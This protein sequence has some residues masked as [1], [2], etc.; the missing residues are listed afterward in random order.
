MVELEESE[1]S[2]MNMTIHAASQFFA[3]YSGMKG[4][5][6]NYIILLVLNYSKF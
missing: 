3:H 6:P 2:S 5:Y 1:S 4:F